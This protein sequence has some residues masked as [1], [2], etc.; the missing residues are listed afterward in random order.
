LEEKVPINLGIIGENLETSVF[1]DSYLQGL[2]D[3]PL[4]EMSSHSFMHESFEGKSYAWQNDDMKI[5]NYM[6]ANV[7]TKK[8]RAFIPPQNE[9]DDNTI[10]AALANGMHVFSAECTWSLTTPNTPSECKDI[11]RVVAPDIVRGGVHMLPAGAVLGGTDYW[12][13]FLLNA[14]LAEA[15]NWIELQIENQGFSVVMLHPVEF[16]MTNACENLNTEKLQILRDLFEYGRSRWQFRTFTDAAATIVSDITPTGVPSSVPTGDPSNVPTLMPSGKPSGFPSGEPSAIPSLLPSSRPSVLPSAAPSISYAPTGQPSF[17]PTISP[18]AS[19]TNSSSVHTRNSF[20]EEMTSNPVILGILLFVIVVAIGAVGFVVRH[21]FISTTSMKDV[22][23]SDTPPRP[24]HKKKS[25]IAKV[26]S[27]ELPR[28][29]SRD[30]SYSVF[31][32]AEDIDIEMSS[33][34]SGSTFNRQ[35]KNIF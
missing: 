5:N 1:I 33:V 26:N 14:S 27:L 13:D 30:F 20:A 3:H 11:V 25:F 10:L 19:P 18:T 28:G 6:I 34:N 2:A 29:T 9:F 22:S 4:I 23:Q 7:T 24:F 15:I 16:A 17:R 35:L 21:C 12:T 31:G 32:D 8:A